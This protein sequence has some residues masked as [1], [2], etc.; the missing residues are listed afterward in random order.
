MDKIENK[1]LTIQTGGRE[2]SWLFTRR[3][4]GVVLGT[5][6]KQYQMEWQSGGFELWTTTALNHSAT[7]IPMHLMIAC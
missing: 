4:G 2:T 6:E 5:T 7:P 1:L 3:S